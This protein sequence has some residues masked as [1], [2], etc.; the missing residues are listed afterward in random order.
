M[1]FVEAMTES[2]ALSSDMAELM[3]QSVKKENHQVL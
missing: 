2:L 1:D 3:L